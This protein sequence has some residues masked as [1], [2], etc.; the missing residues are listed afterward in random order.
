MKRLLAATAC[1]V[2][3]FAGSAGNALA[4]TGA[5]QAASAGQLASGGKPEWSIGLNQRLGG[6]TVVLSE[7]FADITT[8][9]AAGWV[10][11]NQSVPVGTTGWFQGNTDVFPSQAGAPTA[12]IG[13]NFNNTAGVGTIDNWLIT[14]VLPLA[15]LESFSFFARSPDGSTFPDR[16]QVRMNVTNTGSNPADFTVQLADLNPVSTSGWAQTT[17]TSFPG[18]PAQGRLAFRYFVAN[19]GPDGS[20]SDFIGIDSVVAV[21]GGQTLALGTVSAVDACASLPGN[22]NGIIEPGEQITLSL[23]LQA[24]GGAF[25]GVGGVLSS[26]SP[27]VTIVNGIG[28]YGNIAAGASA[29]ASYTV[30]VAESV[31]CS[32]TLNFSLAVTSTEGNFSFPVTRPV[33][34]AAA[35]AYAGVPGAIPDNNATG[36]SSTATVSGVPGPIS[37][38]RVRVN[39]AH[40]WVGDVAIRLT[41]P[42]GTTLT[43]LD[44]P[45]VPASGAGCS[46]NNINVLF[47]DGAPDPESACD[48]AGSAAAWP[49][50]T[51]GPVQAFS[52]LAGQN[53]NGVWTLTVTDSAALDTGTLNSWE[54]ILDPAPVGTCT[55]CP[56]PPAFAL[57][58]SSLNMGQV[59]LGGNSAPQFITVTN[60]GTGPGTLD[61]INFS[62][63]FVRAGGTCGALPFAL[64]AG[65][66][67]TIGVSMSGAAAGSLSGSMTVSASGQTLTASLTG[68]VAS[69]RA[70]IVP[71]DS[72]WALGVLLAALSLFGGLALLRRP[73]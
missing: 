36:I 34:Q 6:G 73:H 38:V 19:A 33:G 51:A 70:A 26:S 69:P 7:D 47:E 29:S 40:T 20:N 53:A 17:I 12:Y 65:A 10:Q 35:I 3:M 15:T 23:P 45:G 32:S 52:S 61:S 48:A 54:L 46:N 72:P 28:S 1:A 57:S 50:A 24:S 59:T 5:R 56:S 39:A 64:A 13:A 22:V 42:G 58:A 2:V 4:Q 49:V 16:I 31:A 60:S 63:P 8:L 14:P 27:G 67:C 21:E 44:R 30:R 68:V 11:N 66:S 62:G 43:L 18:A 71:I 55:V 41:S 25:T 9:T 37:S